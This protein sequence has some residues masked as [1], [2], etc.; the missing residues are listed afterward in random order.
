MMPNDYIHF[1]VVSIK[2]LSDKKQ[3]AKHHNH[4]ATEIYYRKL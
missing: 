4:F 1:T 2:H 3:A